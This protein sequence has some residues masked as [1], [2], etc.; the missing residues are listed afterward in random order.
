MKYFYHSQE[1]IILALDGAKNYQKMVRELGDKVYAVKIHDL[2]DRH[3]P[4]IIAEIKKLGAKR[5]WVDFKLHDIPHTVNLRTQALARAGADIISVQTSGG[6]KMIKAAKEGF[7]K[8]EVYTITLLTSYDEQ[9]T[10]E[11][12]SANS[13]GL[14]RRW[15]KL[16][17][18]AGIKKIVCSPKELT[19]LSRAPE[20][21]GMKFIVPGV[22]S[23][24]INIHD[25][26]RIDTP[27]NALRNGADKLVIGRQITKAKDHVTA[28]KRIEQE[29]ASVKK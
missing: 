6:V 22:R 3:G 9:E 14:V 28:L 19:E 24:G 2:Y 17:Q 11:I 4:G 29:I 13:H 5:V 18:K 7:G 26:S 8:G 10:K 27:V 20:L 16:A 1:R 12:Y 21:R 15:V 25:Q 23:L